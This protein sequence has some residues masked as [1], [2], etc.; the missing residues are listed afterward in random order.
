MEESFLTL[1][2][3]TGILDLEIPLI[4]SEDKFVY[5]VFSRHQDIKIRTAAEAFVNEMGELAK[6]FDEYKIKYLGASKITE[7]A[8]PFLLESKK[9]FSALNERI[10][11]EDLS[12]YPLL[13]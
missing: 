11:K 5:P 4:A 2:P 1:R 8:V 3:D 13:K 9:G 10:R 12:L 7:D 6:V